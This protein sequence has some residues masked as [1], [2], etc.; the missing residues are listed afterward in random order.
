MAKSIIT[1]AVAALLTGS[2]GSVYAQ[3]LIAVTESVRIERTINE[4]S[5]STYR[6]SNSK[7]VVM[8]LSGTTPVKDW[9]MSANGLSGEAIIGFTRNNELARVDFLDFKLP[10]RNL[11]GEVKAMDEDAYEALKADQHK[12]ITFKLIEATIEGQN[13]TGYKV[14]AKGKLTVAGVS[15]TVTLKM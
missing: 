7:D 15:R 6:L 8:N 9:S 14:A 10:V 3:R 2:M 1:I 5:N 13:T 11:K 4:I 12:E